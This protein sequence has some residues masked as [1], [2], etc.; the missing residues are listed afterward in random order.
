MLYEMHAG[1]RSIEIIYEDMK[2]YLEKEAAEPKP[3]IMLYI[4]KAC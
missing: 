4:A 3:A 2:Q 1:A